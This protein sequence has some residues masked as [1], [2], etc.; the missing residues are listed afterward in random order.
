MNKKENRSII[1]V[2][3]FRIMINPKPIKPVRFKMY[4]RKLP[5]LKYVM[6]R[7]LRRKMPML[8]L[9]VTTPCAPV[10]VYQR[11]SLKVAEVC[12]SE[13]LVRT[14]KSRKRQNQED[15]HGYVIWRYIQRSSGCWAVYRRPGG[16]YCSVFRVQQLSRSPSTF[17]SPWNPR[18]TRIMFFVSCIGTPTNW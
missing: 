18:R 1:L 15:H 3:S 10:G 11:S 4:N 9:L 16:T 12:S 5:T 14:Y 17:A 8:V 13:M 2:Q 7:T 6:M